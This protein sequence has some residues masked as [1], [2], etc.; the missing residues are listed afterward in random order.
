MRIHSNLGCIDRAGTGPNSAWGLWEC[1][2]GSVPTIDQLYEPIEVRVTAPLD[3]AKPLRGGA[4]EKSSDKPSDNVPASDKKSDNAG[5]GDKRSDNDRVPSIERRLSSMGVDIPSI[6]NRLSSTG[7]LNQVK[8]VLGLLVSWESL[9][10]VEV[11]KVLELSQTRTREVLR[12]MTSMGILTR[13]GDKRHTRYT[14]AGGGEQHGD[15]GTQ[16]LCRL[17]ASGGGG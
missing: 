6:E 5:S 14:L 15:S 12:E 7:G 3:S 13:R 1:E 10:T 9:T 8:Q 17:A 16:I 2:F 4:I 11:S